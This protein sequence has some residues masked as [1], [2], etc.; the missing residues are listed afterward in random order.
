M[1][2]YN[3]S[4][5]VFVSLCLAVCILFVQTALE[6]ARIPLLRANI[7]T[8]LDTALTS[9]FAC[10]D[11]DLCDEFGIL[12]LSPEDL[13]DFKK[14]DEI[15]RSEIESNLNTRSGRFIVGGNLLR[16]NLQSV[17]VQPVIKTCNMGAEPFSRCI[18]E[19]MKYRSV[20]ALLSDVIQQL[21]FVDKGEKAKDTQKAQEEMEPDIEELMKQYPEDPEESSDSGEDPVKSLEEALD[22]SFISDIGRLKENGILNLVVPSPGAISGK[23]TSRL[24]YPSVMI[25]DEGS[26]IFAAEDVLSNFLISEY[27]ME[28]FRCYTSEK[29][30]PELEYEVEYIISNAASDRGS[31][32]ACV[33]KLLLLREGMN[34]LAITR[35]SSL[36]AQASEYAGLLAGW[37][38]IVP[39]VEFV[40][41]LIISAWAYAESVVDMRTLLSGNKVPL[42]KSPEE[43]TLALENV[44]ELVTGG[45]KG[46][47]SCEKGLSYEEYLRL[48]LMTVGIKEKSA[49]IMDMIQ[50]RLQVY[51]PRFHM[52]ECCYAV[53]ADAVVTAIPVFLRFR[54]INSSIYLFR[55]RSS[56]MY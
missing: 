8:A 26:G 48:L 5:T 52:T 40:K 10:Y 46:I 44:P 45:F 31:L 49:R 3:G 4:I 22:G 9:L 30:G 13:P 35:S 15:L 47:G 14:M 50:C 1:K 39:I 12:L 38:G 25:N 7:C 55:T 19:F 53:E 21:D 17:S 36:K 23:R 34:I 43:W 37:T 54:N 32:E 41:Y 20:S 16:L 11:G 33:N 6:S 27:V 28:Y 18:L 24:G 56:R 42:I 29:K 2:R 51:K